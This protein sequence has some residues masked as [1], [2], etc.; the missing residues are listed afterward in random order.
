M[1][2][3]NPME[4]LMEAVNQVPSLE[5]WD[6]FDKEAAFQQEIDAMQAYRD[7]RNAIKKRW[8]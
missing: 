1:E 2:L 7:R 5:E 4:A 6:K 3:I 8:A